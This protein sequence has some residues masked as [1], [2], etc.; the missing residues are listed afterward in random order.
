MSA[1]PQI[2]HTDGDKRRENDDCNLRQQ[3]LEIDSIRYSVDSRRIV[4]PFEAPPEIHRKGYLQY[5]TCVKSN[6]WRSIPS[7]S[8]DAFLR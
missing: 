4:M 6:D 3:L 8:L 5:R 2:H 1:Q 7:C